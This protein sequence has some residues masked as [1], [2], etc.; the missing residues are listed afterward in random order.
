MTWFGDTYTAKCVPALMRFLGDTTTPGQY[1]PSVGDSI[2]CYGIVTD[3]GKL[4]E[5]VETG[6]RLRVERE[7]II[8]TDPT[9]DYGGVANPE[10]NAT[11][12]IDGVTYAVHSVEA[13]SESLAMLA[14]VRLPVKQ[15]SRE[16]FRRT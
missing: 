13:I 16:R 11:A 14:L 10:T 3:T 9:S 8:S 5:Y 4:V 12:V 7:W 15:R 1:V 6:Q 2:E